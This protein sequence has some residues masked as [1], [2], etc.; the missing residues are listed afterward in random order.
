MP[1]VLVPLA[2]GC[3]EL[4]AVGV[5]DIL[6]RGGVEV[7]TAAL[8]DG[9]I[10]ASRGVRLLA[11]A[12]LDAVRD[13]DFDMIV[14]PGGGPGA[15]RLQADA[16]VI[17]LLQRH[18]G[19]GRHVAAICAAPKVLA[20]AGLLEGKRATGY[21]GVLE[22]LDLPATQ[23]LRQAV[24]I[25]GKVITSQ[26]PGTVI[27]FALCLMEVLQGRAARERVEQGLRPGVDG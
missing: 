10:L 16:R 11:D 13:Q 22:A 24:V 26:G 14:L 9:P 6:R 21:P 25:D 23:L 19:A 8:E 5:I 4:E 3:E 15:E 27:A 20:A 12:S 17:A 18:A 1:R 2:E 7:V